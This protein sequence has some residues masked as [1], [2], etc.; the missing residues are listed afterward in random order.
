VLAVKESKP[1]TKTDIK[2]GLREL[3]LQAGDI[4]GSHSS[5]SSFGYVEGGADT[6]I[7]ALLEVVGKRGSVV[8]PSYSQNRTDVP[9]TPEEE[10]IGVSWK[11][12]LV[13]FDPKVH[14][15]WTGKITD[16][17]WRRTNALRG[18]HLTHSLAAIGPHAPKLI[19]GWSALYDLDGYI[20]QLGVTLTC[21]TSMHLA[22]RE[23]QLPEFIARRLVRPPELDEKY[24]R[25]Q[26][27]VGYGPYPDFLLMEGPCQQRG[28]MKLTRIGIATVRLVK[29]R[30]L[31]D[32]YVY[33]LRRSPEIFYH[34]CAQ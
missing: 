7:D 18:T 21:C 22:E 12:K 33:Y 8:M 3:G 11:S 34:G 13:P 31:I 17:F 9:R 29:L 1:V 16:T 26:W 2:R 19:E 25:D 30:E 28:I 14:G 10:K 5:L 24:P 15:A 20:L 4:V 6:V 27:D 32:L 23:V